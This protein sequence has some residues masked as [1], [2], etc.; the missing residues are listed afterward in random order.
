MTER[1]SS[2]LVGVDFSDSSERA[3]SRA[4]ELAERFGARLELAHVWDR[5][6]PAISKGRLVTT[7]SKIGQ[8]HQVETALEEQLMAAAADAAASFE[9][10]APHRALEAIWSAIGAANTYIDRAAPWAH[11]KRGDT[12]RVHTIL[13]TTLDALVG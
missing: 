2:I 12:V 10:I 4:A 8:V 1:L 13:R 7:S 11:A 3:L 6:S 9:G 5:H